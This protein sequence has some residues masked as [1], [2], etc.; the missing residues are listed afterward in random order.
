LKL[1][2]RGRLARN[3]SRAGGQLT[4]AVDRS[5]AGEDALELRADPSEVAPIVG[6]LAAQPTEPTTAQAPGLVAVADALDQLER[7]LDTLGLGAL[8]LRGD[9]S[10]ARKVLG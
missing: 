1:L 2:G 3:W 6:P 7:C 5:D 10:E 4:D 9:R 8:G